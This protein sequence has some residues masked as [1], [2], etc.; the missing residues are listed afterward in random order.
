MTNEA[1]IMK[2][3][4]NSNLDVPILFKYRSMRYQ[5]IRPFLLLGLGL[6]TIWLQKKM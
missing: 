4:E 5:N 6:R 3:V 1:P 2:S